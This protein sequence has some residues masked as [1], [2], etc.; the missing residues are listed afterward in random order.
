MVA[1]IF[2][3]EQLLLIL[4]A[5]AFSTLF[6][7]VCDGEEIMKGKPWNVEEENKL[8]DWFKSG[9][10]DL[11]VLSKN[12]EGKYSRQTGRQKIFAWGFK[13][14]TSGEK[15]T[16]CFSSELVLPEELPSVEEALKDL[17]AAMNALKTPGL[18]KTEV[19]RL[20]CLIRTSSLYQK[21][22]VEYMDYRGTEKW[23]IELEEKYDGV[24][25]RQKEQM[26]APP[27]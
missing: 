6:T 21:R 3:G 22:I 25:K 10:T 1:P 7:R 14:K 13:R 16:S 4:S 20:R 5:S 24:V 12:F 2:Q 23:L 9:I 11:A 19:M 8:R 27:S 15:N 26:V 18:S 17:A